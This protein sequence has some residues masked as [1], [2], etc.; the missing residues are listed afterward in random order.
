MRSDVFVSPKLLLYT[1]SACVHGTP[2]ELPELASG[3]TE[4]QCSRMMKSCKHV[5]T[6][7]Q[8][9]S[10]TPIEFRLNLA[11]WNERGTAPKQVG[12]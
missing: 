2:E 11:A 12:K 4:I 6:E 3:V 7:A 9:Y 5:A 8:G 10:V 1:G